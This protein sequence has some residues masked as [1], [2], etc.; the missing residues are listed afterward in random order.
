MGGNV[1][2]RLELLELPELLDP[3]DGAQRL[4]KLVVDQ[5]PCQGRSLSRRPP[6][7]QDFPRLRQARVHIRAD[8]QRLFRMMRLGQAVLRTN[9]RRPSMHPCR[10]QVALE[11]WFEMPMASSSDPQW[12]QK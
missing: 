4:I 6:G 10:R 5:A 9:V 11:P 7:L 2:T 8:Q 1:S 3:I 12:R